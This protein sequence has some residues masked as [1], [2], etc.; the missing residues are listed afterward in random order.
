M[1][2]QSGSHSLACSSRLRIVQKSLPNKSLIAMSASSHRRMS[3]RLDAGLTN[4]SGCH[5]ALEYASQAAGYQDG[6]AQNNAR[7][8]RE[9]RGLDET[10]AARAPELL[11][12]L[13]QSPE[14]VVVL[15]QGEVAVAYVAQATQP[16]STPQLGEVHPARRK[17]LSANQDATPAAMSPLRRQ[18]PREEPGALASSARR[19]LRGGAGRNPRP[20]R[21]QVWV[22]KEIGNHL[23]HTD[24]GPKRTVKAAPDPMR[25]PMKPAMHS[26]L[27]PATR[28]DLKPAI[29]P[30]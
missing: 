27:K 17:L 29:V 18:N 1:A 14:L 22:G 8:H 12:G 5:V 7:P 9:N 24:R 2:P 3:R 6:V 25:I 11:C 23:G 16:N 28:S 19:H 15:Q 26:N 13:R 20:Y 4:C 21:D 10:D 30:I